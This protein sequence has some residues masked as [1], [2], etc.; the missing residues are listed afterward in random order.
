MSHGHCVLLTCQALNSALKH[1]TAFNLTT[2]LQGKPGNYSHFTCEE[3]AAQG[4]VVT[5][6]V[7]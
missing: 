1:I 7:Q 4:G 2:T 6:P 5:C 3:T